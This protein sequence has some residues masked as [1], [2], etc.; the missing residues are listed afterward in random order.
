MRPA[1]AQLCARTWQ[2]RGGALTGGRPRPTP[3]SFRSP[4]DFARI[5]GPPPPALA[6]ALSPDGPGVSLPRTPRPR[7]RSR[8][9][10]SRWAGLRR[11][12]LPL[13][14]ET[15]GG[16]P[17]GGVG[18]L[19]CLPFCLAVEPLDTLLACPSRSCAP[20]GQDLNLVQVCKLPAA[21][22]VTSTQ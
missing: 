22:A 21:L 14:Q 20:G 15:R 11:P 4:Q 7:R 5:S 19:T 2:R 10:G 18:I 6:R 1:G 3:D 17:V 12:P 16:S 13:A 8:T 9:V